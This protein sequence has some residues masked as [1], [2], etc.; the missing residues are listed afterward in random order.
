MGRNAFQA[1]T[2]EENKAIRRHYKHSDMATAL[3]ALPGRTWGAIV[4]QASVLGVKRPWPGT[5][6]GK[7]NAIIVEH[8]AAKGAV[9]LAALLPGRTIDSILSRS[10]KLNLTMDRAARNQKP[11]KP[12]KA[13]VAKA[14]RA[15]LPPPSKRA[16]KTPVANAQRAVMEAKRK[17]NVPI[18]ADDIKKL[19]YNDPGRMA[20]TLD[21]IRGWQAHQSA[22]AA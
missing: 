11:P 7:E 1:Y 17:V 9:G 16:P 2:A 3:L 4:Q 6:T 5:W 15:V 20:Y 14:P 12:A 10:R 13:V 22:Q 19:P 21:G 8:Y 18:T